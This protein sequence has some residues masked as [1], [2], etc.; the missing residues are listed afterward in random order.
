M[1][2][3][4]MLAGVAAGVSKTVAAPIE[5]VKLLGQNQD[6]MI[7]QG[8]LDK[9]Y[10][11]VLDCTKR[12]LA[13]E[14]VV[15]F[16][17]G[18]LANVLRYFPTQALN[19]AFKDSIKAMF[20]VQKDASPATKFATNIASGGAAGTMS[21]LFVYSLD[22]ARTRLAN[23]AKGKGGERQFNGLIDVYVKTL[24]SDGIQGLYRGFTIS[25]VG[26]FIYRGMYFGLFDTLKPFLGKDA[27]VG[28]SFL[29][30]WAVTVTAGLMSYPIDTV[31]RR[32]MMTSGGGVKYK[33]SVDCFRQVLKNEGFMSLMKG[34]GANILR[35]V[36]GAG[37]LAGFEKF[38]SLYI[39]WRISL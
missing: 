38:Q 21:L 34:A 24:K 39:K 3:N 17:R 6:E 4:F 20:N 5:R 30:G 12:V 31:R 11:G 8:R 29:L 36:A 33:G 9:P 35:G 10:S 18:N 25:A 2:E 26:I 7:K 22:F 15:P 28:L 37:V 13:T 16:W 32:M 23:D 1:G 19:F 27:N 14:G